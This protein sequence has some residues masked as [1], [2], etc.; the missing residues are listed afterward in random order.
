MATRARHRG[1]VRLATSQASSFWLLASPFRYY[2]KIDS[3]TNNHHHHQLTVSAD[4]LSELG[5]RGE[6]RYQE[7]VLSS[8]RW[9]GG[10]WAVLVGKS[11]EMRI[12]DNRSI[13]NLPLG[14]WSSS[15]GEAI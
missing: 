14:W 2:S 9:D 11:V 10:L 5:G 3:R 12:T 8:Y 15:E 1:P 7:F 13:F 4:E 6:S